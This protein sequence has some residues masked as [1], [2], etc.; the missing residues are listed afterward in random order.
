MYLPFQVPV[1]SDI[2]NPLTIRMWSHWSEFLWKRLGPWQGQRQRQE[3][4]AWWMWRLPWQF[5]RVFGP[6]L[7]H[8]SHEIRD[9]IFWRT[10]CL[11]M[12]IFFVGDWR[13]CKD[14]LQ[15]VRMGDGDCDNWRMIVWGY[16]RM[17]ILHRRESPGVIPDLIQ[18]IQQ[19]GFSRS[20]KIFIRSVSQSIYNQSPFINLSINQ[21]IHLSIYL[22]LSQVSI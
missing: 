13:G 17:T 5:G 18:L 14:L 8:F 12:P 11:R 2:W 10:K 6:G 22:W 21:S 1:W 9:K 20:L 3:R 4:G 19:L 7:G 15:S 16:S